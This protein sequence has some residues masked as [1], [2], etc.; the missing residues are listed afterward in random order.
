MKDAIPRE[1]FSV[2]WSKVGPVSICGEGG[3]MNQFRGLKGTGKKYGCWRTSAMDKA[4]LYCFSLTS[5]AFIPLCAV[6]N[7]FLEADS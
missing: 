2:L 4:S 7:P 5:T 1:A 3:K 6:K